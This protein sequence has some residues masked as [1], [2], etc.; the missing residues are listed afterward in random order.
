M[1]GFFRAI[2]SAVRNTWVS[3]TGRFPPLVQRT[4]TRQVDEAGLRGIPG[5]NTWKVFHG[6][7]RERWNQN[8]ISG[9]QLQSM[10]VAGSLFVSPFQAEAE[11]WALIRCKKG[12]T[13]LVVKLMADENNSLPSSEYQYK[14]LKHNST[15]FPIEEFELQE[16]N[17]PASLR[18]KAIAD[19]N[20]HDLRAIDKRYY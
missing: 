8:K 3:W 13:P 14:Y 7:T 5:S 17:D 9:D 4:V 12:E 16:F 10:N 11:K 1:S 6:T 15:A 19:E 20:V 2:G 18:A